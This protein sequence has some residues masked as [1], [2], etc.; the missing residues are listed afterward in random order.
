MKKPRIITEKP[1]LVTGYVST[2]GEKAPANFKGEVDDEIIRWPKEL[3]TAHPFKFEDIEKLCN[4]YGPI[5]GAVNKIVDNIVGEFQIKVENENVRALLNKF[6]K[7]TEFP[8]T[9]REWIKEAVSKGNGFMELDIEGKKIRVLNA[10][11]MYVLRDKKGNVLKYNQY[12]GSVK[13][14]SQ[15]KVIPFEVD[16][17]AHLKI[18][19]VPGEAYGRGRI[20]CNEKIVENIIKAEQDYSQL[21]TRKAG[22]PLQ[23]KLGIPGQPTNKEYIDEMKANLQYMTNKTEWVTDANTELKVVEFGE[24]GK[25]IIEYLTYQIRQLCAGMQIPEVLLNSGQLNEGIAKTQLEGFQRMIASLQDQIECVIK[26]KIFKPLLMMNDPKW[27]MDVEF[28]WNLPS[29]EEINNRLEKLNQVL[30]NF[31]ISENMKRMVQLEIARL[32]DIDNAEEF[33]LQPELG[34]DEEESEMKKEQTQA[35]IDGT[36]AKA[37]VSKASAEAKKETKIKQPEVPGAKPNAKSSFTE[38]FKGM[39]IREFVNLKEISG[40]NY[41]EYMIAILK[42]LKVD[43]FNDLRAITDQQIQDG[44]LSESQV[45]KLRSIL[46]DGFKNNRTMQEIENRIR[47]DLGLKDRITETRIIPA[48]ARPTMISRT[49]TIRLAN[50]GLVDLFK[51]NGIEKVR[52]LAAL[53]DR[54]CNQ[55]EAL[56]GRVFNINQLNVGENQPPLHVDCRCSLLSVIE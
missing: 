36:V 22:A 3:G 35:S 28:I 6:L 54:T 48:S 11:D 46:K 18:D 34:A 38:S 51:Q 1:K 53:S 8:T 5:S 15:K 56:N 23:A 37:E 12:V 25:N 55:C 50:E 33:L 31:A 41:S 49:E 52:W 21:I 16:Q 17:I 40:F 4:K 13:N 20:M 27:N 47:D 32:L 43:K 26:E 9:T 7:E 39:S 30:Q 14:F 24:I 2:K 45:E 44:L 42:K 19:L 10:K 29:E